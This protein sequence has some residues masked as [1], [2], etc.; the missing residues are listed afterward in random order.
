M[1]NVHSIIPR[2]SL[3]IH[4]LGDVDGNSSYIRGNSI[5]RGYN[6]GIGMFGTNNLVVEDNVI[7]HTIGP[8]IRDEGKGNTY[9]HNLA[10][11][12]EAFSTYK[13][14]KEVMCHPTK[15]IIINITVYKVNI[16][17]SINNFITS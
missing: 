8:S 2:Y 3:A 1:I 15:N 13:G 14:R 11:R 6:T 16:D 9:I 5:N 4:G 10:A 17:K 12:S 7:Y